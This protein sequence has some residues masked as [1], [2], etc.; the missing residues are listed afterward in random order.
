MESKDLQRTSEI[1]KAPIDSIWATQ[2]IQ[3]ERSGCFPY[4]QGFA[5]TDHRCMWVDITYT[6]AFGH[7]M[8][9]LHKKQAR[10]LQCKDPR[11]IANYNALFHQ[12]AKS[13]KLFECVKL[14]ATRRLTLSREAAIQEYEG[15]DDAL[16][17]K[18]AA[19]AE[20]KCRKLRKG[21]VA[22]SPELNKLQLTVR[23]WSVL[24]NKAIRKK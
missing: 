16:R 22:F 23:A 15:I 8:A 2:G 5:N 19:F 13:H 21:T 24:L 12:F 18:A 14:L 9:P 1:H 3:I 4:D 17:H 10:R 6:T 11:L 7:N 20:S